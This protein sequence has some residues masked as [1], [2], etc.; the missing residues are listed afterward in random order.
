[1]SEEIKKSEST[2]GADALASVV[3]FLV[4]LPLCM[5]IAIASGQPPA[6][7]IITGIVGG[8]V[9]GALSGCPL[10]VS[11]PA[12]GLS[13]VVWEIGQHEGV[14]GLAIV[15]TL[16]GLIQLCAGALRLGQWFRAV[17]PA[18]IHG[19]LA[20][21]GI[22]IFASQFHVMVDDAPR[23]SGIKNLIT[24]PQAVYKGLV[25]EADKTHHLAALTGIVTLITLVLWQMIPSRRLKKIPAQL[26]AVIAGSLMAAWYA[27][28]IRYVEV[29]SSLMSAVKPLPADAWALAGSFEIWTLAFAVA[30]VASAETLL[31][32]GAVDRLHSG[33]RTS[34]NK[35]LVAQGIGNTLCG[36]IGGL[37]MTGVIVR[38]KANVDAGG[39]SRLSTMLHGTWLV[40]AVV[41]FPWLLKMVPVAC[42]AGLLVYTGIKLVNPDHIRELYKNAPVDLGIYLATVAGIVG[43]DLLKGV[44]IGLVL[45]AARLLYTFSH[46]GVATDGDE[47]NV[48]V[49]RLEGVATFLLLPRL[50]ASLEAVP[51]GK[52][53]RIDAANLDYI[54]HACLELIEDWIRQREAEGGRVE[55]D[56][57][58]LAEILHGHR[59]YSNKPAAKII[60]IAS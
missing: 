53:V 46:L 15:V 57:Q 34:Y 11:G 28:P 37:P 49:V 42:L 26:V 19:M 54:D 48:Q 5:G 17:P 31:S 27:L 36:L 16:A 60:S 23:G 12:A 9:V 2:L 45:S 8:L 10:Q 7:G 22:L 38:S 21:I 55:V 13:V 39:K 47:R 43:T 41:A 4:A 33:E 35:E 30:V 1:M 32:A 40:V 25:P 20:G 59:R 50:A 6:A 18:V 44:V 24:V 51:Q 58:Q 56:H 14:K 29:P 52:R 3:V